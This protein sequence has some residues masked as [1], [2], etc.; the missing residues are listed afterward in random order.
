MEWTIEID[1]HRLTPNVRG[2]FPDDPLMR[3]ADTVVADED[4]NRSQSLLSIRNRVRTALWAY[5]ICNRILE[6]DIC[7]ILLA[8][9][10]AHHFGAT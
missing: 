7:Q 8:S 9:G 3:G 6:P 4:L 10:D 5:E 2:L 1:P